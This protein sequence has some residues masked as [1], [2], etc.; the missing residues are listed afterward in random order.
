MRA[1]VAISTAAPARPLVKWA[2]GKTQLLPELRKRIPSDFARY[3]EPFAGGAA[4]FFDLV[5][6]AGKI[7]R[8]EKALLGRSDA[9]GRHE[10]RRPVR[11]RSQRILG[12]PTESRCV[13]H[14]AGA[15]ATTRCERQSRWAARLSEFADARCP[16]ATTATCPR[17][18]SEPDAVL[19][20][21]S[22]LARHDLVGDGEKGA[23]IGSMSCAIDALRAA[24]TEAAK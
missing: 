19:D 6:T 13:T 7:E 16:S 18:S 10:Q 3:F 9:K 20:A 11:G 17:S 14:F 2:G 8:G 24:V 22:A 5:A 12:G 1:T 23:A 21:W 4:L 15:V